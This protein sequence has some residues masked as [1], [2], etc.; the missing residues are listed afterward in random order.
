MKRFIDL[1]DDD[2]FDDD[3]ELEIDLRRQG[4]NPSG[5]FNILDCIVFII[6][7][8]VA[9]VIFNNCFISNGFWFC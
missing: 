8:I 7:A 4:I 6:I 9:L 3:D 2:P 5:D 1:F